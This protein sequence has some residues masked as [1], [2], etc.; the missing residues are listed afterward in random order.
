MAVE[1]PRRR[2]TARDRRAREPVRAQLRRVGLE[3]WQG[4]L[5]DRLPEI[6]AERDQVASVGLDGLRRA[7]G[8]EERQ[9]PFDVRIPIRVLHER[10][11]AWS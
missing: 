3:L 9:E 4:R 6:R 8:S 5:R 7:A 11:W 10:G 1:A 2:G